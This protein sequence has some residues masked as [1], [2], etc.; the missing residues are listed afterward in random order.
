MN[1]DEEIIDTLQEIAI[2]RDIDEDIIM[3]SLE[4]TLQAA[5]EKVHGRVDGVEV[6]I[7][8][9]GNITATIELE[10]VEIVEEPDLEISIEES[11]NIIPTS[12]LGDTV[13]KEL[14][15]DELSRGTI[16]NIRTLLGQ[17]I[18][19][20]EKERVLDEFNDKIGDIV[21]GQVQQVGK[22]AIIIDL[23]RAEGMLLYKEQISSERW[24][25]GQ[26]IK[27]IVIGIQEKGKLPYIVL[28]RS[29][30]DF[31]IK[32]FQNE[33]PEIYDG[34]IEIMSV[35]RD[36][37]R[38]S[39]VAV[40]SKDDRIDPVGAC[41][42]MKGIRVQSIVKELN[43]E[44]IDI[45][46]WSQEVEV[47]ITRALSPAVIEKIV[48]DEKEKTATVTVNDEQLS[49]AIGKDGQNAR[50][51]S[52]LTGW[53]IDIYSITESKKKRKKELYQKLE[54]KN[55]KNIP[56]RKL[57]KLS[58][59]YEN[60]LQLFEASDEEILSIKGIKEEDIEI[61]RKSIEDIS[62]ISDIK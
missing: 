49:L 18:R 14:D 55:M 37:G 7:G 43:G 46:L 59:V 34:I 8:N 22:S 31:L 61:I 30:N 19:E 21:T 32:L 39:K 28:S 17:K 54:V 1:F 47:F 50:L 38:R 62:E 3:K 24:H 6:S 57:N 41:V 52:K 48:L 36:P 25:Q 9:K 42:G 53:K 20:A 40:W 45:V 10:V 23:G 27:A 33:V 51:A 5:F 58:K 56:K 12:E 60:V 26:R 35:A 15:L 13:K 29:H 16:L 4:E 2:E 44:K 11:R